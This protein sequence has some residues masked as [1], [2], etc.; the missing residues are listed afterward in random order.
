M[1]IQRRRSW[2][3]RARRPPFPLGLCN[4]AHAAPRARLRVQIGRASSRRQPHSPAALHHGADDVGPDVLP[5]TAAKTT[6]ACWRR[7]AVPSRVSTETRCR[8]WRRRSAMDRPHPRGG[9][10]SA[11]ERRRSAAAGSARRERSGGKHDSAMRCSRRRQARASSRA[12]RRHWRQGAPIR[13]HG[14][15][16]A[17]STR[18]AR[19]SSRPGGKC[20][21]LALAPMLRS[22]Q[23]IGSEVL[24]DDEPKAKGAI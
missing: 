13:S 3:R 4:S 19:S 2:L 20:H 6:L 15:P 11:R 1:R 24:S 7:N 22:T 16:D 8:R 23:A 14:L 21:F 10:S 12:G 5:L 18:G 17:T 9:R